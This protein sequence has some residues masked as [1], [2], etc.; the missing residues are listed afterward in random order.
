MTRRTRYEIERT[1][2]DRIIA[3]GFCLG[4]LNGA[5]AP[6]QV[7]LDLR[8]PCITCGRR[9]AVT[10]RGLFSHHKRKGPTR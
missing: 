5:P 7:G 9:V 4:P 1:Q 2:R 8:A 10:K 3:R 6:G